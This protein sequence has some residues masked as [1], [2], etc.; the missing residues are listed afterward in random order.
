MKKLCLL[1]MIMVASL[2]AIAQET[3]TVAEQG[4]MVR[5]RSK[6]CFLNGT[7]KVVIPETD[8][9]QLLDEEA[10]DSYRSGRRLFNLGT[11]LKYGGYATFAV[12]LGVGTLGVHYMRTGDE[13]QPYWEDDRFNTG[14]QLFMLGIL[15]VIYGNG[16]IAGGYVLRGFGTGK[17]SRIAEEY[18]QNNQNTTVSYRLSP[19]VMP[20][21]VPQSQGNMAY[22]MTFSVNF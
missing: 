12:G 5:K 2:V 20:V 1:L 3:G 19:A 16:M 13:S 7:E 15:S 11:G 18:N 21:N 4:E 6:L 22:G 14:G 10:Y 9:K 17:I 8:L